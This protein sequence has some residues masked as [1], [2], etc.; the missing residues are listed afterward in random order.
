MTT[1]TRVNERNGFTYEMIVLNVGSSTYYFTAEKL[2]M[3]LVLEGIISAKESWKI[4]IEKSFQ[5]QFEMLL[6]YKQNLIEL[7]K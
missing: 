4:E 2:C 5:K 6:P 7:M 3:K 1:E